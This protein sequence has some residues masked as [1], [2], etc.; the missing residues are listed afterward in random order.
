MRIEA[1]DDK[2]SDSNLQVLGVGNGIVH[3]GA[4]ASF[5]MPTLKF[6]YAGESP[7]RVWEETALLLPE[8]A[9]PTSVQPP[10]FTWKPLPAAV[11]YRLE[12]LDQSEAVIL[13]AVTAAPTTSYRAPSWFWTRAEGKTP[14]WRVAALDG[15]GRVI[16]QTKTRR[17]SK[18]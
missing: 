1:T 8:N 12:I 17:L 16:S 15:S 13:S 5:P 18:N 9:S 7:T 11:V 2:E 4:V 14:A 6:F 3:S 10:V